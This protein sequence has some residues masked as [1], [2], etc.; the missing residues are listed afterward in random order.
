MQGQL[1]II[2][3]LLKLVIFATFVIFGIAMLLIKK[4]K[5]EKEK[6]GSEKGEVKREEFRI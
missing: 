3:I 2:D 1:D 6:G 5:K 4:Q